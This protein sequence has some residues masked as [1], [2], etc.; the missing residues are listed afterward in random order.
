[1]KKEVAISRVRDFLAGD[2]FTAILFILAAL[3]I[4]FNFE[5]PGAIC[6]GFIICIVLVLS[7]DIVSCFMPF[8]LLVSFAIRCKDSY[9][10]FMEYLWAVPIAI[11]AILFHIIVYRDKFHLKIGTL[12]KPMCIASVAT[13]I[14]GIGIIT[15]KEYF[16]MLSLMYMLTLG[17]GVVLVYIVFGSII[18]PGKNRT[19]QMDVRLSK[20]M[21]TVTVYLVFSILQYYVEH[22]DEF[23]FDPDILPFQ[24]RNNACTLM[25]IAMPFSFY[26]SVKKFPYIITAF[27]SYAG[28][29]LS[30]SRGGLI[31]GGLELMILIIYFA[32]KDKK[33]RKILLS[34]VGVIAVAVVCLIPKLIHLFRYTIERLTAYSENKIRLGL[35]KRSVEDFLSNPLTGRGLGYMGNRDIHP[36]KTAT[37]CWYHSSVPQVIGSFGIAG[38]LAYGYQMFCRIRFFLKR[39]SLFSKTV[40]LSFIGLEIMSIVNPG[41]FAPL[42]LI[43]IT[44]FFVIIENY[45]CLYEK[46][47]KSDF[48][49]V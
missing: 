2:I 9:N 39:T 46:D 44:V 23:I 25:M 22:W 5:I 37:L 6:F 31:F 15:A 19:E 13:T 4:I 34:I 30:G 32:I 20:I 16:T 49:H 35:L 12:T 17:F 7:D 38:I 28:M 27:L 14:G 47:N 42:Y 48:E 29:L 21:I 10:D 33:H 41:I 24:W 11:F 36:S 26:M 43:I 8:F 3:V 45:E 1:M 40:F 18:G